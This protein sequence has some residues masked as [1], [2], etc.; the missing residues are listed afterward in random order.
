MPNRPRTA[1]L[2]AT[3][4]AAVVTLAASA[5][6]PDEDETEAPTDD[7]AS[8]AV[9]DVI[10]RDLTLVAPDS[11]APGWTT[12]RFTNTSPMIHFAV[13]ER[14]PDGIGL[15]EQQAE[16]A[17]V[18]QDGLDLLA[19]GEVDAA[20]ATFGNLPPWFGEI[21]F[22]GGPGLTSPGRTSEATVHL[23][24]GRYLLECYVK[25]D[26]VFHSY[27]PEEG[28]D[29]MVHEFV[30]AGEASSAPEPEATVQLTVSSE[31]GLT[32]QGGLTPGAHTIGVDFEDQVVHE[33][34]VGHDVH[35]VRLDPE[36]DLDRLEAWMDWTR[37]EGL[38]SPAPLE[39]LGGTNEMPAG[40]TAYF[41]VSFEPGDYAWI[42]EVP[43]A[44]GKGMLVPFA[45]PEG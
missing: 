39:F 25:T 16:V 5:C 32:M 42:A 22:M 19:A 12:F 18:F 8:A 29:G 6:A 38:Q 40:T 15:A 4:H 45:V 30:V 28:A 1:F 44:S 3:C 14:M 17:P 37:P 13:V 33:N 26:G 27:N 21:V 9:V 41:T 11:I 35:V 31:G 24:P 23:E 10:A 36:A 2:R 43:G 34:F 7:R 20:M